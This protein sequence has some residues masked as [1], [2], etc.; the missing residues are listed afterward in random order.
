[1]LDLGLDR[2]KI[3][4]IVKTVATTGKNVDSLVEKIENFAI[5]QKEKL[6]VARKKRLILWMLKDIIREK[7]YQLIDQNMKGD[8]LED[9]VDQIFKKETDPYT[10]A[11]NFI[12][13]FKDS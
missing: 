3:P 12:Q 4:P 9:Y 1:M 8:D 11:E 7:I 2:K 10:I 6:K 13:N 5:G